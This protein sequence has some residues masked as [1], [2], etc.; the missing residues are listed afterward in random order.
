MNRLRMLFV[1]AGIIVFGVLF[2]RPVLATIETQQDQIG[3]TIVVTVSPTPIA[4]VPH[5][6]PAS[7]GVGTIVASMSVHRAPAAMQRVFRAES[8]HFIGSPRVIAQAQ[9]QHGVLVQ[10]EVT[11]NPNATL[12]YSNNNLVSMSAYPGQTVFL[13]C[14]FTVTVDSTKS[15]SL[16]E[17][18]SNDF[19]SDWNGRTL[20]NN[21]YV[22]AATPKPTATP[23]IV[24]ADDGKAWSLAGTGKAM[25]T[26]CVDLTLNVPATIASGTYSTNA[27]YTVL[28]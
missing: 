3:I 9:V 5:A 1:T 11:P 7:S 18:L 26:Y 10:A 16:D 14:A 24:Y 28:F 20:A 8:L 21:T 19:A 6:V 25:T 23:Y 17:G 4:Y 2:A 27:I 13:S 12:L 22:S 15:W